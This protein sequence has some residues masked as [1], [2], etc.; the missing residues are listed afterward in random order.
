MS[1]VCRRLALLPR[2][3]IHTSP[4]ALAKK[5]PKA[6]VV[7]WFDDAVEDDLIPSAPQTTAPAPKPLVAAVPPALQTKPGSHLSPAQRLH[8]FTVLVRFVRPRV[9]RHPIKKTPLVR[10]SAFPQ[11]LHLAMTADHVR[12]ISQLMIP[13]KEGRL[14]TQGKARFTPDGQPK[15]SHPFDEHT[16]EHFARRCEEL[17]IPEHALEVFGAFSTYALPLTLPAARRLLHGLV[18][19]E[20][21]LADVITATALY[22]PY[23]LPPVH[24]DLPSC[25]LLLSACLRHLS[26]AEGKEIQEATTL[27]DD[28]IAALRDRL[29]SAEPMPE[30]CDI[31]DKTVRRW[32]KGVMRDL[33]EFLRGRNEQ[34][35]W[36][37]AWMARS[38]FIPSPS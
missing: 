21:P 30:S 38:R 7:D 32:L 16:S 18:A 12:T 1:L 13:W 36:L 34:R 37:E 5:K 4:V 19:A 14:G 27:V 26:T 15:G 3:C 24:N 20:R 11:L 23:G 22:A 8:D 25:A 17:G 2:R 6:V 28:L 35:D 31:R 29:A 33:N 9:G 10:R